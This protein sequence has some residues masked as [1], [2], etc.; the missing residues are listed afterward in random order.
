VAFPL[1]ITTKAAVASPLG[2]TAKAAVASPL[3]TIRAIT[4]SIAT[5]SQRFPS[6]TIQAIATKEAFPSE[7]IPIIFKAREGFPLEQIT[8]IPFRFLGIIITIE[9]RA[10]ISIIIIKTIIHQCLLGLN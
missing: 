5:T 9:V 7:I 3:E 10:S 8:T 2:I 6:E 4:M 1:G